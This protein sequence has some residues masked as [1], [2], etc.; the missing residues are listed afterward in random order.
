MQPASIAIKNAQETRF[1]EMV[2]PDLANHYG[3]L[4]GGNALALLGKSAFITASRYARCKIVMAS[5]EQ[6]T[7]AQ[8]VRIGQL[9]ELVG[10]VTR[11]G[12]SSMTVEVSGIAEN[13][14]S[15][16]RAPA[17][18]GRFEMVAVD[19]DGRPT[20]IRPAL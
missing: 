7:F 19:T 17:L 3:T 18:R 16:T 6:I 14:L 4:Y 5:S 13:L 10:K 9:L 2:L 8:P 12:H 11:V 20:A 1:M 15:G